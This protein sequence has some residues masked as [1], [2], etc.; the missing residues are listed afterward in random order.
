MSGGN[1][2]KL[3][4]LQLKEKQKLNEALTQ[5]FTEHLK[6]IQEGYEKLRKQL[7]TNIESYYKTKREEVLNEDPDFLEMHQ[8][9]VSLYV[10]S[11]LANARNLSIFYP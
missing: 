2:L 7:S 3:K 5:T 4:V 8:Q 11:T 10:Q 1:D 6:S 9:I